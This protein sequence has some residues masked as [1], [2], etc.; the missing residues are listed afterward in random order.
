MCKILEGKDGF[1][2]LFQVNTHYKKCIN[3]FLTSK[4]VF[5]NIEYHGVTVP[6]RASIKAIPT[7]GYTLWGEG[8]GVVILKAF[9]L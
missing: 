4:C 8:I 2:W 7:K 1:F 3:Y 9:L 5:G 6:P